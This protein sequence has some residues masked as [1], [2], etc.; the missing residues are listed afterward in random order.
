MTDLDYMFNAPFLNPHS[1]WDP[2]LAIVAVVAALGA[3]Y[4][5]L[6]ENLNLTHHYRHS[7]FTPPY[8]RSLRYQSPVRISL[9]K[10]ISD[11]TFDVVTLGLLK[12]VNPTRFKMV[13]LPAA[14]IILLSIHYTHALPTEIPMQGQHRAATNGW[15]VEA[16]IAIVGVF[17]ALL[18]CAIGLAWP[19]CRRRLMLRRICAAAGQFTVLLIFEA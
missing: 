7:P 3:G 14:L 1:N 9:L 15:S 12:V 13:R 10:V 18:C 19:S 8:T 11:S 17:V 16:I 6:R 4:P 2:T 5:R